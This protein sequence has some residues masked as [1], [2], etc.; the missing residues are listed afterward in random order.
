MA[1]ENDAVTLAEAE[2]LDDGKVSKA[3]QLFVGNEYA[4]KR[5]KYTFRVEEVEPDDLD[6]EAGDA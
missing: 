3:G 4:G 1:K 2:E 6:E 5:V